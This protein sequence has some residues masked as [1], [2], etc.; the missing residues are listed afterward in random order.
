MDPVAVAA[1]IDYLPDDINAGA[2][3]PGDAPDG[4]EELTQIACHR[5]WARMGQLE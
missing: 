1:L 4:L 3:P 2:P 5:S